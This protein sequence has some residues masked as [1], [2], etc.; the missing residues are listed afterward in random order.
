MKWLVLLSSLL[1]SGCLGINPVKVEPVVR[2]TVCITPPSADPVS[3]RDVRPVVIVDVNGAVWVG[4]TSKDYE[5]MSLNISDIEK[6]LRQ[7]NAII[8]YYRDCYKESPDV[9]VD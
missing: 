4:M 1:L 3:L 6:H 7:K 8:Q 2:K 5:N 9:G